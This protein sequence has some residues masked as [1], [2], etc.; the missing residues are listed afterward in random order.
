MKKAFLAALTI[1]VPARRVK[2]VILPKS[3]EIECGL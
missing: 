3:R 2:T 1:V